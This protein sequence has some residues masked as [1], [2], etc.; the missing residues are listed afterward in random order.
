MLGKLINKIYTFAFA[1]SIL[2]CGPLWCSSFLHRSLL[3]AAPAA[4]A[5]VVGVSRKVLRGIA[6]IDYQF[7]RVF[8]YIRFLLTINKIININYSL[9]DSAMNNLQHKQ[10]ACL[11]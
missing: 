4:A 5:V 8:S 3:A 6:T 7:S 10:K 1:K 9:L 2:A 11:G